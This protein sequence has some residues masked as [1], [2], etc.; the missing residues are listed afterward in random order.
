M[1]VER[2]EHTHLGSV[3]EPRLWSISGISGAP[4][5]AVLRSLS[6]YLPSVFQV[7]MRWSPGLERKEETRKGLC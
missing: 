7:G 4:W 3:T 6:L 2:R 1:A 5:A